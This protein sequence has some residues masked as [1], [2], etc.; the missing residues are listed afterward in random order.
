M[1]LFAYAHSF[2]KNGAD[3]TLYVWRVEAPIEEEKAVEVAPEATKAPIEAKKVVDAQV[4]DGKDA[5]RAE[6][7]EV[8][9]GRGAPVVAN[10]EGAGLAEGVKAGNEV[11]DDGQGG[12]VVAGCRCGRSRGGRARVVTRTFSDGRTDDRTMA[13]GASVTW[14]HCSVLFEVTS[15]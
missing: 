15:G 9:G 14:T 10:D 8:R 1:L 6:E 2:L 7:V 4:G 11:A 3:L 12:V 13:V 5:I